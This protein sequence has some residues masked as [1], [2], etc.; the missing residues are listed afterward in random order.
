[1]RVESVCFH[2]DFR[3]RRAAIQPLNS[4]RPRAREMYRENPP[5]R[6]TGP[7]REVPPARFSR[8]PPP[9]PFVPLVPNFL[10]KNISS[11]AAKRD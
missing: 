11:R 7:A 10:I 2:V 1:M 8:R 3:R 5:R 9:P 4:H 6:R